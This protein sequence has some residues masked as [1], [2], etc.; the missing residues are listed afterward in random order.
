MTLDL[1]LSDLVRSNSRSLRF[2]RLIFR[3]R[4]KLGHMLGLSINRKPFMESP[5]AL[6]HSTLSDLQRSKSRS[7]KFQNLV[8]HKGA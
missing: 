5:T 2:W 7:L 8:S 6:S 1:T 3:K 4:A